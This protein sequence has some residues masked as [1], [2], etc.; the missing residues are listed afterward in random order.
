MQM[1]YINLLASSSPSSQLAGKRG[2]MEIDAC[3]HCYLTSLSLCSFGAPTAPSRQS[4]LSY[5]TIDY[6]SF[7]KGESL[8]T[9]NGLHVYGAGR[10]GATNMEQGLTDGMGLCLCCLGAI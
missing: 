2:E 9:P 8:R 4:S 3:P 7:M 5:N 6:K 1:K 10:P